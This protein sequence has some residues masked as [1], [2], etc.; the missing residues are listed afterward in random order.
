LRKGKIKKSH[1]A[2]KRQRNFRLKF[3]LILMMLIFLSIVHIW[4]RVTVLTL[5]NEI[6][7]LSV[8]IDNQQKEY[9]YIQVEVAHLSSV[10]RIEKLAKKM[11]FVYPSLEQIEVFS[12]VPSSADLK[13]QGWIDNILSRLKGIRINLLS[14]R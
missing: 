3:F 11:G 13:R 6:K 5:A 4:Q 7:G 14:L 2:L 12:E 10:E 9:K 8:R 1:R